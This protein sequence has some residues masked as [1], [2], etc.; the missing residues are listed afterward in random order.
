MKQNPLCRFGGSSE[1]CVS[2][3]QRAELLQDQGAAELLHQIREA[4]LFGAQKSDVLGCF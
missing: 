4:H 2:F 3:A 1:N